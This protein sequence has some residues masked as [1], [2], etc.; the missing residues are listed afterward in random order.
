[1]PEKKEE[2]LNLK[3]KE[4]PLNGLAKYKGRLEL[5][6]AKWDIRKYTKSSWVWFS[7]VL[8]FSLIATQLF[9]ILEEYSL[10]PKKIPIFQIYVDSED[11][12]ASS[13]LI[14]LAPILSFLIVIVGIVVS[15]KYYNKERDLSNT[16]LWVMFLANL[17]ITIALIRIINLY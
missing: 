7:I 2:Q 13:S 4:S 14:F 9:T 11:T 3:L 17:V 8:S 5:F 16:L 12:L 1:M 10:L 15:N 6:R